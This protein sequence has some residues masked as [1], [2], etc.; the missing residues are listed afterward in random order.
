MCI[1][2]LVL[3]TV[4][5]ASGASLTLLLLL[6]LQVLPRARDLLLWE[7]L[8][9]PLTH[10]HFLRRY[11]GAYGAKTTGRS[12]S[13]GAAQ[14]PEAVVPMNGVFCCGDT[15]FPGVGTPAVAA[16][17]MWVANTLASPWKHWA[18]ADEL[19]RIYLMPPG[20]R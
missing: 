9:T 8:G 10:Q 6:L 19:D 2:L 18:A 16:S 17:G 4:L 11:R 15:T 1:L 13:S 12:S 3:C 5:Y 20:A 7:E 14:R